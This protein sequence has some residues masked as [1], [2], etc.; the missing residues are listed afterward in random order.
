MSEEGEVQEET[1]TPVWA[2]TWREDYAGEDEGKLEK[3]SRYATPNAAFDGLIAAN[4]KIV[5]GDYKK[6]SAFPGE[7]TEDEQKSWRSDNGIPESADK[8]GF[9]TTDENKSLIESLTK[10]AFDNNI[11]PDHTKNFYDWHESQ[12]Q[13]ED[14]ALKETDDTD[15]QTT[16]DL[17]RA[18]WGN[19]YRPH[20]NKIHG[21][22]DTA[23]EGFK[24][25]IL[26][27]RL[28]DGTML[29]SNPDALKFLIDLALIK[30]PTTTLVPAG[31]DLMS[32]IEDELKDL[33]SMMGNR[34]SEYWKGP[35][36]EGNQ[37]RY[38]EL[39]TARDSMK[40]QDTVE[41][42]LQQ[43]PQARPENG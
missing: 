39:A 24:E 30:N 5:S 23:P 20:M 29:G 1:V 7:G 36:A 41:R 38:R 25:Q 27:A 10:N 42:P 13:A 18:E 9:E 17:L 40:K 26:E 11:S 4:Q 22:L 33:E 15:T 21:L 8:Y 31:G 37:A 6:V 43:P 28:K 19:E 35:K 32:S 12:L 14:D 2:D 16:E 34:S 3:L